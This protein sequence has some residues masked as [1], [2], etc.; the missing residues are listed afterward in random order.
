[1][2]LVLDTKRKKLFNINGE[3]FKIEKDEKIPISYSI[4][5]MVGDALEKKSRIYRIKRQ[6]ISNKDIPKVR[7]MQ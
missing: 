4:F 1:M 2:R 6:V 3:V 5:S 7:F